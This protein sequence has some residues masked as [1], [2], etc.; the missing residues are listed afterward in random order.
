M[1]KQWGKVL[2]LSQGPCKQSAHPNMCLR[3]S[4]WVASGVRFGLY[5]DNRG[6]IGTLIGMNVRVGNKKAQYGCDFFVIVF[7]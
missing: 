4:A 7:I 5:F 6:V 3:T 1:C 2:F